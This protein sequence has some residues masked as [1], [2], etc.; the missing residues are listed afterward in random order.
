M[1]NIRFTLALFLGKTH[2]KSGSYTGQYLAKELGS[3][4]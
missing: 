2:N 4:G 1:F 3:E